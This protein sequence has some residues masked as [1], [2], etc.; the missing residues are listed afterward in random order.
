MIGVGVIGYGYWGPNLVRN[1]AALPDA[2]V[3]AVADGR[4]GRLDQVRRAWPGA[5]PYASAEELIADPAVNAVAI[6]TPVWTHYPLAK[7]ALEAGKHVLLEK[8][9]CE[10]GAKAREL[11]E[12]AAARNLVLLVDHTFSYTGAVRTIK[13]LIDAG[14]LGEI[15]Y[16]DSVRINLG[17]FQP[18]V[19]VLWDL[20]VH[21]LSIMDYVLGGRQPLAVSATGQAHVSTLPE[22]VAYLTLYFSDNLIA[23][24]HVNWLSPVKLRKTL[25]GGSKKMIVYDDL[26]AA[27]KVKIYD[28]GLIFE[29]G[30]EQRDEMRLR[31]Y[32]S[33]DVW[34]PQ[35][36]LTEALKTEMQHFVRCIEGTEKPLTDGESGWRVVRVLEAADKS[37]KQKGA[38]V[39]VPKS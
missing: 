15:Y 23:H 18:D 31:G 3:A 7:Q 33:G 1:F 28:K 34:S 39:E 29:V 14:D 32:R 30:D 2:R 35:V 8:P 10:T 21:D 22:D 9:L 17:L 12:I 5:T 19:S 16:Y 38:P 27:E 25:I 36:D 11:I 13:Q 26:E 20:A 4:P 37:M 6:A 24:F